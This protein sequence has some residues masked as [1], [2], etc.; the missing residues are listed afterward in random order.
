MFSVAHCLKGVQ[1]RS[2]F[3]YVFSHIWTEYGELL[4]KSPCSVQIWENTYQT[5][6]PYLNIFRAVDVL[7]LNPAKQQF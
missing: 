1:I 6:T 4:R 2:F 5:K 3:W 7:L